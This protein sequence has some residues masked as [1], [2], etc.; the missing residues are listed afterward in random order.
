LIANKN[1]II[2]SLAIV[3]ILGVVGV[4]GLMMV[5]LGWSVDFLGSV[6]LIVVIGLS[7][8]Y[9]VHLCHS[10]VHSQEEPRLE[11]TKQA[12]TEM[13][14][15]IVSGAVT[16]FGASFFLLLCS[17]TFFNQ[18]GTFMC[19]T[20]IVS[21][22]FSIWFFLTACTLVGPKRRDEDSSDG[23]FCGGSGHAKVG[24]EF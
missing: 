5:I 16:S 9:T 24:I 13:G 18:F 22:F 11:R 1:Y 19:A 8:D 14:V 23:D 4:I 2:A 20:I 3:T 6:C 15:S 21:L 7:V 10:Y 17:M 12:A